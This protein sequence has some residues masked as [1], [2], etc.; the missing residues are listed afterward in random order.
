MGKYSW[1]KILF[2]INQT[3]SHRFGS[4]LIDELNT[5]KYHKI[6][7]A[8][9]WV[10]YSGIK[11]L[12]PHLQHCLL[13]GAVIKLVVGLDLKNTSQEGLAEL[14]RLEQFG[15]ISTFVHHNEENIVFHPKIYLLS[16]EHESNLFIGSNNVTEAGLYRNTEASLSLMLQ[17][18]SQTVIDVQAALDSWSDETSGLAMRLT[19]ES[20]DDLIRLNYVYSEDQLRSEFVA[21]QKEVKRAKNLFNRVSVSAPEVDS[22]E[23]ANHEKTTSARDSGK[24]V[25]I[26]NSPAHG[27]A[28]LMRVRKAHDTDRPTQTQLP[29][30]VSAS[31]FFNGV[32]SVTS[33]HDGRTHK[34]HPARARGI[35]NTIKLEIPEM[36]YFGDPV[37]R[38]ERIGTVIQYSAF[39]AAS[40]QGKIIMQA[41]QQGL[42]TIP[43]STHLTVPKRPQVSTWWRFI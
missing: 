42:K 18:N 15:N 32:G 11:H 38:F 36:K 6:G 33:T 40:N 9:A 30:A 5:G 28:L 37:I 3:L 8:V 14:L 25:I 12:S 1:K 43:P 20:L 27:Q 23:E 35:V 34:V 26:Q 31:T 19:N 10:R 2:L 13:Q 39:D 24:K 41:L 22:R 17:N 29:K 21:S 7:V 16:N 4:I